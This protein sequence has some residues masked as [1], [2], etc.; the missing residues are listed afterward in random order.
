M[1]KHKTFDEMD[2]FVRKLAEEQELSRDP[3]IQNAIIPLRIT[4]WKSR[5][6]KHSKS[7]PLNFFAFNNH[8]KKVFEDF[9]IKSEIDAENKAKYKDL[10]EAWYGRENLPDNGILSNLYKIYHL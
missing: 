2:N 6:L 7:I 5:Q 10:H 9:E 3:V 8:R 4:V 1:I